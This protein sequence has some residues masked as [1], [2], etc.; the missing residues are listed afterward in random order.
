M[1]KYQVKIGY[2]IGFEMNA[3]TKEEAEALA[4][5]VYDEQTPEPKIK[6]REIKR[7]KK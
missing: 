4:W 6:I 7:G 5:Q 2:T 3:E 1:K